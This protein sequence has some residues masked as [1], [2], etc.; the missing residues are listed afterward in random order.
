MSQIEIVAIG[1]V[2]GVLGLALTAWVFWPAFHG[3]EAARAALGT[4]RLALGAVVSVLVLNALITLPLAPFLHLERGLTT[5]TF[6]VAALSTEI[7]ML[8][9]VYFRLIR[10]GAVSWQELGLRPL[11]MDTV[12]G[13]GLGGGVAGLVVNDVVGLAL[14]QIGLRPNQLEQF[15][16][17]RS[18]GFVS[19]L[20]LLLIAG[21]VAPVVEELFFRGFLFGTYRRRQPLWVAY[22][23]SGLLF[24]VLHLEPGRMTGSQMSGL[25][26]GIFV[27]ALLLAWLYDRTGSLYPGIVAHVVNNATGLLL[28]Y[29]MGI[30]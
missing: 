11:R 10:P 24:T 27:L 18:E 19:F 1:V 14:S 9:V 8:L 22:G 28:F 7:P 4:H 20:L 29:A 3:P 25:A 6:L 15:D 21:F 17:V 2:L 5:S 30:Q 26:I 16:F 12:L 13:M 23:A